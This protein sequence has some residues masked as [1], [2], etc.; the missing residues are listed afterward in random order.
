ML[1]GGGG[2]SSEG[3]CLATYPPHHEIATRFNLHDV[4]LDIITHS[5]VSTVR[6]CRIQRLLR[7][8]V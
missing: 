4:G 7:H 5:W 6:F 8:D 1:N 2:V 3:K